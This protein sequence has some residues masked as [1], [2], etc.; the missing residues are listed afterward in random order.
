MFREC[1]CHPAPSLSGRRRWRWRRRTAA[2][3]LHACHCPCQLQLQLQRVSADLPAAVSVP[4]AALS[5]DAGGRQQWIPGRSLAVS[6]SVTAVSEEIRRLTRHDE[7]EPAGGDTSTVSTATPGHRLGHGHT[8]IRQL[9]PRTLYIGRLRGYSFT[10]L[11]PNKFTT[12]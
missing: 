1:C 7:Q 11:E 2:R 6:L 10:T 4:E 9:Q 12:K 5:R 8:H 3:L